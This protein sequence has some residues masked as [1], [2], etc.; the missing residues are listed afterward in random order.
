MANHLHCLA[1][2]AIAHTVPAGVVEQK[3]T[4][5]RPDRVAELLSARAGM[6]LERCPPEEPAV[7]CL[8]AGQAAAVAADNRLLADAQPSS[9]QWN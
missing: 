8:S 5:E 7:A 9:S 3:H 4:A 6:G 2:S 1:A